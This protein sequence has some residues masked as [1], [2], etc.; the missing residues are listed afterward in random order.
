MIGI[1]A[2]DGAF[3]FIHHAG[4][5][6]PGHDPEHRAELRMNGVAMESH[7]VHRLVGVALPHHQPNINLIRQPG[8]IPITWVCW[9]PHVIEGGAEGGGLADPHDEC[10]HDEEYGPRPDHAKRPT[11]C[12]G[13]CWVC[14]IQSKHRLIQVGGAL[15]RRRHC[16]TQL[17]RSKHHR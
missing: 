9:E 15:T 10:T 2:E 4:H 11:G 1:L 17:G 16:S 6:Q 7:P 13:C 3:R 14:A 12:T 8:L 5:D